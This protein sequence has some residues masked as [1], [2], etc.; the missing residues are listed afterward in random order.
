MVYLCVQ[1]SSVLN[2]LTC[3]CAGSSLLQASSGSR[4]P[5]ICDALPLTEAA[6]LVAAWGL[7]RVGL[8]SCSTRALE[9]RLSSCDA[10]AQ[11][12][13]GVWDPPGPGIKPVAP[14]LVGGVFTTEPPGE[15]WVSSWTC[16][17]VV[18]I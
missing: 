16:V 18:R 4:G 15:P 2:T 9:P 7:G 6:S 12:V 5:S 3:G 17:C 10:G 1:M 13:C 14:A 8:S 11:L